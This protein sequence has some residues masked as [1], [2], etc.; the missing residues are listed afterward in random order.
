VAHLLVFLGVDILLATAV[1][2]L[3]I[4]K[5]HLIK[6]KHFVIGSYFFL[7]LTTTGDIRDSETV[8]GH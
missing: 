4:V 5:M 7:V 8:F 3:E 1:L 2:R 6:L